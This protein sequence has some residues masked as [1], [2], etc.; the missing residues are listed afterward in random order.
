MIEDD[1]Q[2]TI[3]ELKE[4]IANLEAQLALKKTDDLQSPAQAEQERFQHTVESF[5]R[6]KEL[7][8]LNKHPDA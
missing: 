1:A 6:D 7:K 3:A 8:A 4:R 2:K 5:N